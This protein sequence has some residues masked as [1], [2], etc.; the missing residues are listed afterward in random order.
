MKLLLVSSMLGAVD[1]RAAEKTQAKQDLN[2]KV[3]IRAL[4][5]YELLIVIV[6]TPGRRASCMYFSIENDATIIVYS[7]QPAH[8][9]PYVLV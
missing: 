3:T 9:L 5:I 1:G 8:L 6:H 2:Q 7:M 4:V